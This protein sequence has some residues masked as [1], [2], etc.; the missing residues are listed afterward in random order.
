[1]DGRNKDWCHFQT[2]HPS[3][4][5]VHPSAAEV[6]PPSP[7]PGK[8]IAPQASQGQGPP[9]ATSRLGMRPSRA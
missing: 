5:E 6:L 4:A 9:S 3:A 7:R 1:M 2:K 8:A